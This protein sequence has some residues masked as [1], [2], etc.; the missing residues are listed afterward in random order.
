MN[1]PAFLFS[2]PLSMIGAWYYGFGGSIVT[3]ILIIPLHYAT[4]KANADPQVWREAVNP[5][6]ICG[7]LFAS[8]CTALLGRK[9]RKYDALNHALLHKIHTHTNELKKLHH[10]IVQN[11]EEAQLALSQILLGDIG[12]LLET[13]TQENAALQEAL[14]QQDVPATEQL[15]KLN[16]MIRS[17]IE[18]LKEIDDIDEFILHP[19]SDLKGAL[20][21]IAN[22]FSKSAGIDFKLNT[23]YKP[24]PFLSPQTKVQ[25]YRIAREAITNAIKHA[26]GSYIH[27]EL[28]ADPQNFRLSVINDGRPIPSVIDSGLGLKL[29]RYR[30]RQLGGSLEWHSAPGEATAV[31]CT[32]PIN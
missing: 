1:L 19:Q 3:I 6:G 18:A 23:N 24:V 16:D 14:F 10:Y 11:H 28:F 26:R 9:K 25:I 30:A 20:Q 13:M 27:I 4:L 31:C 21:E 12:S 22:H 2:I 17:S 15:E 32:I 5:F 29:M 7:Q 8:G